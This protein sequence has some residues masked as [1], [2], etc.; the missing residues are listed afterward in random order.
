MV[1]L[2]NGSKIEITLSEHNSQNN[3]LIT[4]PLGF[5]PVA[6][7]TPQQARMLA[8]ELIRAVNKAEVRAVLQNNANTLRRSETAAPREFS[9]HNLIH[10]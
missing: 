5:C 2:N 6:Q 10:T 1:E 7:L 8:N 4:L 3:V 9:H